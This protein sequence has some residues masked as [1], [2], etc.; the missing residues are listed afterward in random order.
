MEEESPDDHP[1]AQLKPDYMEE[2]RELWHPEKNWA[3]GQYEE[4]NHVFR[5]TGGTPRLVELFL[6]VKSP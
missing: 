1:A 4:L 3:R 2:D 5:S 6:A